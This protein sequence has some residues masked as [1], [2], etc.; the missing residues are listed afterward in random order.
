MKEKQKRVSIQKNKET[1]DK[2][3]FESFLRELEFALKNEGRGMLG[4]LIMD[5]EINGLV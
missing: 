1:I 4:Y 2:D 3:I 5:W